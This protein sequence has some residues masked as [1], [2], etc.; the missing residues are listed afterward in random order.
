MVV[1]RSPRHCCDHGGR[2]DLQGSGAARHGR[3]PAGWQRAPQ[4]RV[5]GDHVRGV[6][7]SGQ[8]KPIPSGRQFVWSHGRDD[9][10]CPGLRAWAP[11]HR[12]G[13]GHAHVRCGIPTSQTLYGCAHDGGGALPRI[14]QRARLPSGPLD[15]VD[16]GARGGGCCGHGG[17]LRQCAR[18]D[19]NGRRLCTRT[20]CSRH[21]T[22]QQA[23]R[24]RALHVSCIHAARVAKLVVQVKFNPA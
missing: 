12:S 24:R 23:V 15:G 8:R 5:A 16:V 7:G 20:R 11:D 13:T 14:L 9:H 18:V 4:G 3:R 1:A 17:G 10:G 19:D 6:R 22:S 21:G 2:L